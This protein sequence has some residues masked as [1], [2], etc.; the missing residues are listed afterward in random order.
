MKKKILLMGLA[1]FG[2]IGL[3]SCNEKEERLPGVV[4]PTVGDNYQADL[5]DKVELNMSVQYQ[6]DN[7]RIVFK[8]GANGLKD[9]PYTDPDGNKYDV[10]DLKPVWKEV[11][12]RLNLTI[13]DVATKDSVND[14]FSDWQ[15]Q[16]WDKVDIFQGGATGIQNY[17]TS[18]PTLAP[19]DLAA[20]ME[21]GYLPN[22]KKFLAG[23][24]VVKK[25]ITN[26]DGHIYYAPYFDGYDD[27][28]KM[29]LMRV[30][31]VKKLLDGSNL[32]EGLDE[33]G[34][35][36]NTYYKPFYGETCD[37][38]VTVMKA[39]ASGTDTVT[40]K[41]SQNVITKQNNLSSKTGKELVK[42]LRD[43]IDTTYGNAYGTNRSNLFVGNNAAYDADEL[44]A[45]FRCVRYNS[46]FLSGK[47]DVTVV[48]LSPREVKNSRT[49]D[50]WG[51]MGQMF[52]IR[53]LMSRNGFLYVDN[54]GKIVDARN[55]Q[56]TVDGLDRFRQL[57]QEDLIKQSFTTDSGGSGTLAE[58]F[59][60]K[61]AFFCSFDYAQT[62]SALNY[63]YST[64][65]AGTTYGEPKDGERY[66]GFDFEPVISPV[67][68][69]NGSN[70]FSRFHES[71]RSVKTEGWA[72]SGNL[73]N[74]PEKL[75]RALAVFDY[76]WTDEGQQ[77]MSYGPDSYLAKDA[78]GKV[79]T[80]KY[81]GRDVP[82]LSDK[83][84]EQLRTLQDYN[85]TN[86]YRYYV[87]GTYPIGYIKEQG[88]EY[89]CNVPEGKRGLDKVE[90]AIEYKVMVGPDV[91]WTDKDKWNWIVP[92][93]FAFDSAEA[94]SVEQNYKLLDDY[95]N[96]TNN[97]NNVWSNIVMY[98]WGYNQ[99]SIVTPA[100]DSY[101]SD[102]DTTYKLPSLL[103]TY[104]NAWDQMKG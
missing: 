65:A 58:N 10:G 88:M 62:Q 3:V 49:A 61:N 22:F 43:Y 85:Y 6:K 25:T 33:T 32:P 40:K 14:S 20:Y 73:E 95:I 99:N 19:I 7:T 12:K 91:T 28:E 74:N 77:L 75:K 63:K 53:G 51:M 104:N 1:T 55:Q 18:N 45:L 68:K 67:A 96:N 21:A 26:F 5:T 83:T 42:A 50:L 29:V 80:I 92:T 34:G 60:K 102:L 31:F 78:S 41:Y 101:I 89:Q 15:I 46:H 86:Y 56:A 100:K 4:L 76:F 36:T 47:E 81:M 8:A 11:A 84:L 52:G 64:G 2:L 13:K 57:Y 23:N 24:S 87:G 79:Q 38:K 30:D 97:K 37:T 17:A 90:K 69:W 27:I 48:P 72:I 103:E 98:G 9:L 71:W 16:G 54:D 35:M 59:H 94:K 44:V 66:E 70:E 39:D 93:T 82:K